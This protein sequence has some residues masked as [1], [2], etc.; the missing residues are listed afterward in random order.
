MLE[1]FCVRHVNVSRLVFKPNL[2][3]L[4]NCLV[5]F[6]QCSSSKLACA[7][8]LRLSGARQR[9]LGL[10]PPTA[11]AAVPRGPGPRRVVA[12]ATA[13]SLSHLLDNDV[14]CNM[15]PPP[16][17]TATRP[18]A[19]NQTRSDTP[20]VQTVPAVVTGIVAA[21]DG[22]LTFLASA[23]PNSRVQLC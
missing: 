2:S 11:V 13:L 21:A 7:Q 5:L 12:L 22:A 6:C 20:V 23:S 8:R 15:D 16:T 1:N 4:Q 18:T 14:A 19:A 10:V 9:L 3:V 17:S